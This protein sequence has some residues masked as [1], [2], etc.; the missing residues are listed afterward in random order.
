MSPRFWREQQQRLFILNRRP[1]RETSLLIEA[2]TQQHGK[3]AL[4]SKGGR[5]PKSK[6]AG[7][8]Q[9]FVPLEAN[10]Q[11]KSDI[12]TL[13]DIERSP[14][15]QVALSGKS[16]YCGFYMNELLSHF[17]H[18][19]DAHPQLFAEY[20]LALERLSQL[21]S[22][23]DLILRQF[24]LKLLQEVGYGLVLDRDSGGKNAIHPEAIYVYLPEQ[25][26][27]RTTAH[28]QNGVS[29]N[30]QTLLNLA[31]NLPGSADERQQAKRL[32]RFL[33]D[34]HL[35]GKLLKSRDLFGTS[36]ISS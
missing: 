19:H 28:D 34:H 31:Q 21:D 10:W 15:A 3:L 20:V 36:T 9:P 5:G 30:G 8:L 25:G 1:Y 35:N 22:A 29:I 16:M 4:I 17:L 7:L 26:A 13:T 11:G 23:M 27:I 12:L 6:T 18:R 14:T 33:I 2:F 32:M 24:E